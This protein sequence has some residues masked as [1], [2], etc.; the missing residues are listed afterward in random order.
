MLLLVVLLTYSSYG[1]N[2]SV[3]VQ[4]NAAAAST[5]KPSNKDNGTNSFDINVKISCKVTL[6]TKVKGTNPDI[7]K[8]AR[9]AI[10]DNDCYFA[11]FSHYNGYTVNNDIY[12]FEVN[13]TD[14]NTWKVKFR[15][16]PH[17]SDS[18]DKD[19]YCLATVE[20]QKTGSFKGYIVNSGGPMIRADETY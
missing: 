2:K 20:K 16:K 3:G 18:Y 17:D 4:S 15:M 7:I 8:A 1:N 12:I 6:D 9:Q 14:N 10:F 13:K 19:G 5:N 11:R